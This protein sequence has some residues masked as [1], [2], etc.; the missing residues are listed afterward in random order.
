MFGFI[1]DT[2][3]DLVVGTAEAVGVPREITR[4]VRNVYRA[5]RDVQR[6]VSPDLTEEVVE[7]VLRSTKQS[8]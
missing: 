8:R 2:A 3:A 7:V 6:V 5:A 4:P 1:L